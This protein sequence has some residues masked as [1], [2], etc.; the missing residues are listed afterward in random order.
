MF[1]K[2]DKKRVARRVRD[3]VRQVAPNAE[4]GG[5]MPHGEK[6]PCS[7]FTVGYRYCLDFPPHISDEYPIH[8]E[9]SGH[10]GNEFYSID[11]WPPPNIF[12]DEKV[13]EVR[14]YVAEIDAKVRVVF[15]AAGMGEMGEYW[16]GIVLARTMGPLDWT[17]K[18]DIAYQYG[19]WM[20]PSEVAR[21]EK[22]AGY[23][24][25]SLECWINTRYAGINVFR[26]V[27]VPYIELPTSPAA[28]DAAKEK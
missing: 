1:R 10:E 26:T 16:D 28:A 13:A 11:R 24:P 8:G 22:E 21:F 6:Y 15:D 20:T 3:L 5:V 27:V 14:P 7:F 19:R 17:D 12:E 4:A 18:N 2:N 25:I 9:L 23:S